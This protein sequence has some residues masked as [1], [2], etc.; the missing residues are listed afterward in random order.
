MDVSNFLFSED[1]LDPE[2]LDLE[3]VERKGLGHPDT[4]ADGIA[5]Y[6]SLKYSEYCIEKFGIVL[7]HNLDKLY[8]GGGEI[9][10]Q[11]DNQQMIKPIQLVIN[12]RL[13]DQFA[14]INIDVNKE[15]STWA[16]EYIENILPNIDAGKEIEVTVN[17]NQA[18]ERGSVW[19]RPNSQ[20]DLPEYS[21]L[22]ANDTSVCVAHSPMTEAENLTYKLEQYFWDRSGAIPKYKFNDFGQDIKVMVVRAGNDYDITLCVPVL[23]GKISSWDNYESKIIELERKLE[24]F[25]KSIVSRNKKIKLKINAGRR[26]YRRYTLSRGTCAE[27]G[28]EGI[29]GRGNNN[30]GIIPIFRPHT[31]EAPSGKNPKYHTGKVLGY[32]AQKLADTIYE[33]TG[34]KNSV[35][36]LT[37][38]EQDLIPPYLVKISLSKSVNNE[39]IKEITDRVFE[40][41]YLMEILKNKYVN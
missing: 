7:H 24:K 6:V 15:I 13:S 41:D 10:K 4:L 2:K 25:A 29:V 39:L 31:M 27:V 30:L 14:G 35:I 9:N 12:G 8:I 11:F 40:A 5:N 1:Y 18:A 38:N 20:H 28:E 26:G 32:L 16:R 34:A 22:Y 37:K 3:I 33:E 36:F 21:G 17:S 19:Y 23:I